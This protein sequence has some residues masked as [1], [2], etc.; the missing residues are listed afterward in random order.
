MIN[1]WLK[2]D[3]LMWFGDEIT[4][5]QSVPKFRSR[6]HTGIFDNDVGS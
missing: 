5:E 6:M 3:S 1:Q 4:T 2:Y